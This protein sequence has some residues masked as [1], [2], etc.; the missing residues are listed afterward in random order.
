M[1]KHIDENRLQS[2]QRK[3]LN[4]LADRTTRN[5]SQLHLT[6]PAQ[7][8][9]I[10]ASVSNP[11]IMNSVKSTVSLGKSLKILPKAKICRQ[12]HGKGGKQHLPNP[13]TSAST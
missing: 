8:F 4:C 1:L 9:L 2:N 10:R 11:E 7:R 5:P 3:R 13:K 6:G 12:Y